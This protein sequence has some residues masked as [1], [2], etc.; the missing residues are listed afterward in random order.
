MDLHFFTY[1]FLEIGKQVL[2]V[3]NRYDNLWKNKGLPNLEVSIKNFSRIVAREQCK[4]TGGYSPRLKNKYTCS[5]GFGNLAKEFCI[6]ND[7]S[8]YFDEF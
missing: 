6:S 3:H 2:L 4:V 5:S 8:H 7:Y 1:E